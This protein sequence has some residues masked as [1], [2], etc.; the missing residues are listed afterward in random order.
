MDAA[1]I[2]ISVSAL[3]VSVTTAWLTLFR[4]GTIRMTQPTLV[5]FGPD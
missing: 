1:S 2:V 4:R 5:F 3:V